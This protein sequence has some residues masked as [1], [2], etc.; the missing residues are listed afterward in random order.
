MRVCFVAEGCYPYYV[1][2]VSSWV[3]SMIRSFPNLEFVL[4]TVVASRDV[5]G[6]FAYTLPENVT[7]VHE[8]YL[9]D[10]NWESAGKRRH[11]RLSR[12]QVEALRSMVLNLRCDWDTI[13]DIFQSRGI[14]VDALLMGEDFLE[15]VTELYE[16]RYPEIVFSDFLWT[17]RSIYL[18]LFLVLQS[19][20][21]KADL[22][23]C[24]ATRNHLH[25]RCGT[26]CGNETVFSVE[27][28][29]GTVGACVTVAA[30]AVGRSVL[31]AVLI[32]VNCHGA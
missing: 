14:S 30:H 4:L 27:C 8:V 3:D 15:I 11:R 2:G 22:Y 32:A 25:Q 1:G 21:P 5:R 6:K 9:E 24:V 16:R 29:G 28:D 7:E 23:H 10:V 31:R 19:D 17:M 20:V 26:C 13:F 12:P 18:P